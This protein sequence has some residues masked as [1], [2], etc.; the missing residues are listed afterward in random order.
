MRDHSH[1]ALIDAVRAKSGEGREPEPLGPRVFAE[2][3]GEEEEEVME[4]E[5]MDIQF[6]EDEQPIES[7]DLTGDDGSVTD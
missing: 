2:F 1:E 4:A 5:D 6:A 7:I 3:F